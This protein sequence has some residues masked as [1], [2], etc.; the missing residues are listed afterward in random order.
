MLPSQ[1]QRNMTPVRDALQAA[2]DYVQT[3]GTFDSRR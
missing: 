1:V 2:I 3:F